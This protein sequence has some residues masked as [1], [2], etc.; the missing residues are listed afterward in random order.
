MSM[1][2]QCLECLKTLE[3]FEMYDKENC[4]SCAKELGIFEQPNNHE[5]V[6]RIEQEVVRV[7]QEEKAEFD[8][9]AEA[10]KEL[11]ERELAR[12]RLLPFIKRVNP[13]YSPGWVHADICERLEKFASDVENGLSPRL[14]ITMPPRHGKSEI[15]SK[16]FPSWYLGRNPKHEVIICSYAADLAEDFSRKCRDL[17]GEPKYKS[18]FKTR[19]S[20]D[21]KSVGKWA[22]NEGGSFTAAGVGGPI[23]GRGAH[24]GIIDDPVKNREEAESETGRQKVKDWYSSVFYTRLAPGGGIL[25][26]Q[27]RWHDDDL[28]GHLLFELEQAKKEA[29]AEGIPISEDVDEWDLVEYPAIAT[30]DEMYRKE[31]EPLHEERYP[32]AALRRIKR[33]MIPRDWEALYQQKPVSDDGDYFTRNMFRY[34]KP[35]ECPPIGDLRVYAA[36]DLAISTKQTADYSVFAVVGIDRQQNIWLLDIVRGR[37]NAL[38][39]ID[40]M[41]EIQVK[42]GPELFGIETGQIELTL[43]PFIQKAEQEKGISLRY[44]KLRTRGVDKGVRARPLQGRMEQN[45]VYFPTLESTPWMSSLQNELLKFPLGKN[46]DQ[47]DALA[48]IG[49]MIM[50]FGVRNEKKIA[51]PKTF[52]DRLSQFGGGNKGKRHKSGMSA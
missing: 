29:E 30:F 7:T 2:A 6:A 18:V 8:K 37:W 36:A 46:D 15:G 14:M 20:S 13:D 28:A 32:L 31:G 52:K 49:Q 10:K 39:I 47:V 16:T 51:S 42:Y 25:I 27:T 35:A 1:K 12:R 21:S 3:H 19:L 17:I 38:G 43:E 50:L 34:Y 45:K 48:W 24:V 41:F 33:N 44:E 26:I 4:I 23:T 22:T 40:R 11:A 9:E 5:E